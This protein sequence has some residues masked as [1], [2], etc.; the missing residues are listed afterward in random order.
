MNKTYSLLKVKYNKVV[1]LDDAIILDNEEFIKEISDT[2]VGKKVNVLKMNKSI[3]AITFNVTQ[4]ENIEIKSINI[5]DNSII[6]DFGTDKITIINPYI[7]TIKDGYFRIETDEQP[8]SYPPEVDNGYH[9]GL[10]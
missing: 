5:E 8:T 4:Y 3:N 7:A 6:V 9:F 2:F 10:A 1:D